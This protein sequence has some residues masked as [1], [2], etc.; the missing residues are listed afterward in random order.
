MAI[1][2][3]ALELVTEEGVAMEE[4]VAMEERGKETVVAKLRTEDAFPCD[5]GAAQSYAKL[6]WI[7]QVPKY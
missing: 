7:Y 1:F 4:E 3:L 6:G 5:G 2:F